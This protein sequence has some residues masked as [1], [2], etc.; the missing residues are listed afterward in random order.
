MVQIGQDL[1]TST[2]IIP[3]GCVGLDRLLKGGFRRGTVV[4]LYGEASTGKT[5]T[6]IQT[7][8]SATNLGLK[9]LYVDADHSFTQ[10]RFQQIS[11]AS[12]IDT[13]ELITLS[14]PETFDEQRTL[15]E[16][17]GSYLTLRH[18]LV[19]LDSISSLYRAAFSGAE[20]IFDLNRDLGRQV[21]YIRDLSRISHVVCLITSQVHSRLSLPVSDVEP[22]ARRT[23]FHFSDVVLR[24]R[25]TPRHNVKQFS[26]EQEF[27][28]ELQQTSCLIVLNEYG[29]SDAEN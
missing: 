17:L 1:A 6:A 23:M 22:V 2:D 13:S 4:L 21:A 7:A 19:V 9:V 16:S 29:L 12:S 25:N 14:F 27:G 28:E 5:T 8:V 15:I 24:L 26:L 10:Q 3:T 20:S 18:G 11:S